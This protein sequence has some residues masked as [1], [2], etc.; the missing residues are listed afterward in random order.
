M[1]IGFVVNQTPKEVPAYT[2]TGL[3]LHASRM[4][5]EIYYI[6]VGDLVYLQDEQ[7]GAH[8]RKGPDKQ[9]RTNE[10]FLNAVK[11]VKK[12][13]ITAKE[14]DVLVLRNDPS[15][16][17]ERRPW[18]QNSGIVFG[19]LAQRHGVVVLN[20]PDTLASALNKMYFQY[21]PKSVRPETIITRNIDDIKAFYRHFDKHIILKPLQGSGGKNVFMI[22][23][24]IKNLNQIVEAISR[25][26][27]VVAQ[28]Y[29]PDAKNGDIRLFLLDGQPIVVDGKTAALH[30]TQAKNDIRSNIHQGGTAK[31]A[32]LSKRCYEIVEEVAPKLIKDGMFLTGLDIV[33]DK[34]MEVNV[35]SPGGLGNAGKLNKVDFFEPVIKAIERKVF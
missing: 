5:H 1:K 30:R 35:F 27:F 10:T 23:D 19:Q 11:K 6:G 15:I 33:G 26:G 18:A 22:K 31:I 28:E 9:F 2:T 13:L 7:M 24:D 29:L 20:D 3:A 12:E 32:K 25:D 8:A 21:F 14:L 16:D 4:G 34:L 17:F